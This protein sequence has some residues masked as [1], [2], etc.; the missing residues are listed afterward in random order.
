MNSVLEILIVG[1]SVPTYVSGV[2][3]KVGSSRAL[4]PIVS[5]SLV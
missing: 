2:E 5:R 3:E 4:F 1:I